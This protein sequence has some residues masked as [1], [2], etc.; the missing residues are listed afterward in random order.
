MNAED[1]IKF[2]RTELANHNHAYY[3]LNSPIVSDFEFDNLLRELNDL[4]KNNPQFYDKNSPTLRVGG[5]VVDSFKAVTHKYTMLS[6]ANTYSTEDLL[7][8]DKRIRKLVGESFNYVCELK[9]D[10]VSIS[11]T[12][13]SGE[14]VQALT[15]GDGSKGD[16]V[17]SN[18][19]TIKSIPLKLRGDFPES[20]E[21]RGEIFLPLSS[22]NKIN[23]NRKKKS[24]DPYSNPRNTAAGSLKLLDPKEVAKR[25]LDCF[26]YHFLSEELP[27][28]SHFNNLQEAR[29]LGF[30][31][32]HDIELFNDI[33]GVIS[34]VNKWEKKRHDLPFEIDGIVIKVDDIN[35][36]QEMGVT[37]KSP[38]W[39]VSYKFKAQQLSTTLESITYQVGRTGAIT[40]VANLK[41]I[42]LAGTIVKRASLHNKDQMEKIDIRERDTLFIEKGGEIIPKVVGVDL[43]NRDPFS[44]PVE[45]IQNCPY[46]NTQLIRKS[47][48]AKH[49]CINSK[50]C[51]PQIRGVFEHFISRKAMNIDGLGSE[52]IELLI[53]EGLIQNISDLY[54]LKRSDLLRLDRMADKSVDNLLTAIRQSN[55]V[56]FSRVLFGLG[57]RYVGE[58]VSK[59]LVNNFKTIDNIIGANM[60]DLIRVNEIGDKIAQSVIDWFSDMQNIYLIN[61]LK[62]IGLQF[63]LNMEDNHISTKLEGMK[64]VISGVFINYSRVELQKIIEQNGGKLTTSISKNTTFVLAGDNM[65]PNKK[66]KA[67]DL[68]VLIINEDEFLKKI[69]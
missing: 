30:K 23:E 40:P 66:Q 15:R 24:L 52:T 67:I 36:Q 53:K 58:T 68:G 10:G 34:F 17:T 3:V 7:L 44:R 46:C 64:I 21:I 48:D 41:P 12:Y 27:T 33:N 38:R 49:Y 59:V 54:F 51:F 5:D 65:G 11:L 57:I 43:N 56:P 35:L 32:S 45:Y 42:F 8:F 37:A 6:L 1:K 63:A 39:A 26:L 69:D 22:F 25:S 9:Y 47:G 19:R 18:I 16:D 60:E 50:G 29:K 2:L 62:S 20:F 14:L 55:S 31:V 61:R 28:N 4:E 13:K